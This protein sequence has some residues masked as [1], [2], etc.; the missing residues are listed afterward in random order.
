[1]ASA[2]QS[3]GDCLSKDHFSSLPDRVHIDFKQN[4]FTDL[5][6]IWDRWRVT[7]RASF[8]KKYG[9]IARLLKVQIDEQLLK[10]IVQFWDSSYRRKLAKMMGITPT[11]VDQNLRKKGDNECI[12]WS[13]LRSYIMKHQDT[14]QGQLVM[15]LG[16]YGLV[17]FPKV[18]GH[19]EVEIIDF[20][21]QVINKANPSPSILAE[22]LRSLNYCRRKGK[23]ELFQKLMSVEVTWR[24]PWMPHHP[25]LYKCKNEPWVPLMG[26]WGAISYASIMVRRQFGLE[27]FV[28]MT[29]RLNTLE[30]AYGESGF[31]KRIEEIARAWKKIS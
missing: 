15:A 18:L 6:D 3:E 4:D 8:D 5:L 30:F 20:F 1:M 29:H 9:H 7:T 10:A 19:I 28:P 11:E 14:E 16:I 17:I 22:T 21:E 12:P 2:Q 26:P 25:I 13:F 27:Q 24:A 23:D 31:L